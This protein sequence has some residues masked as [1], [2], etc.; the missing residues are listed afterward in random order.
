MTRKRFTLDL[1]D[2]QLK[3]WREIAKSHGFTIGRGNLARQG[4]IQSLMDEVLDGRL[5]MTIEPSQ[6][7]STAA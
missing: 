7:A 3:N 4:S 5:I 1:T 2:E 6:E